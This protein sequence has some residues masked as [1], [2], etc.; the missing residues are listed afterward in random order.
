LEFAACSM[1]DTP[2]AAAWASNPLLDH[3]TA[4]ISIDLA[5]L[6]AIHRI[7]KRFD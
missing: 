4:Q 2:L 1:N 3:A 6:G 7:P 5:L